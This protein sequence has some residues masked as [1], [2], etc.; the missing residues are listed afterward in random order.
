M[1]DVL[2]NTPPTIS[3]HAPHSSSSW[4]ASSPWSAL[5]RSAPSRP[6]LGGWG[7]V[8]RWQLRVASA[9]LQLTDMLVS[10]T[11]HSVEPSTR[12]S[13]VTCEEEYSVQSLYARKHR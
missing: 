1:F 7:A 6:R 2:D 10:F 4:A 12:T 3:A 13:R 8:R 9:Q 11:R 5:S